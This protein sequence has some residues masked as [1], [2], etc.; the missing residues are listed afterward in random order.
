MSKIGYYRQQC[1]WGISVTTANIVVNK[2]EENAHN[3]SYIREK[4]RR[5]R[6]GN[7]RA[8]PTGPQAKRVAPE[9]DRGPSGEK[10]FRMDSLE[11]VLKH[12]E[13]D[14]KKNTGQKE[15]IPTIGDGKLNTANEFGNI[16]T[17]QNSLKVGKP[18]ISRKWQK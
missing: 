18:L 1:K 7:G 11:K 12:M 8:R 4:N 9:K 5:F 2:D 17:G 10:F 3:T 16:S 6:A 14:A 13:F 15:Q